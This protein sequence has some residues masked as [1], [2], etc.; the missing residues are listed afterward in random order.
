M[1]VF[2]TSAKAVAVIVLYC[3]ENSLDVAVCGGGHSTSASSTEGGICLDLSQMREVSV[4]PSTNHVTLQGGARWA[5]VYTAAEK[6]GLALV[7]GTCGDV[8]VGGLGLVGRYGWLT[9]AH[10]LTI[11]RQYNRG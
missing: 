4:D 8:G 11:D 5:E 6:Y 9:A 10:G 3:Q 1:V 7:G 2:P